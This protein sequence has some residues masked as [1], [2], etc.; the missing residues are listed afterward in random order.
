[1]KEWV[2]EKGWFGERGMREKRGLRETDSVGAERIGIEREKRDVWE[3]KGK[4]SNGG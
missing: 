1:M 2:I 3:R 4:L